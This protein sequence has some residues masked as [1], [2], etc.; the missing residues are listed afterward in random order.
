MEMNTLYPI[1]YKAYTLYPFPSPY[2]CTL[3]P[4]RENLVEQRPGTTL[5]TTQ[6]QIV[7]QSFTDATRFWWHLYG[8]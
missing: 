6:G 2:T 8:M 7:S 5:E 4:Q 1:P 3:T